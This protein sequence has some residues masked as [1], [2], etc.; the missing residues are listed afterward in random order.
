MNERENIPQCSDC[1]AEKFPFVSSFTITTHNAS[2]QISKW[3]DRGEIGTDKPDNLVNSC[4][5]L[6]IVHIPK[7]ELETGDW[8]LETYPPFVIKFAEQEAGLLHDGGG[9]GPVP[10]DG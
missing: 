8:R 1:S 3:S 10:A 2:N 4:Y 6:Y 7:I 5:S 9:A